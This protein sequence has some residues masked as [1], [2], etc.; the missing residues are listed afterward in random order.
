MRSLGHNPTQSELED[1]I[2][3]VDLD[4]N[5]SIDFSEFLAV[6]SRQKPVTDDE[7]NRE[8]FRTFDRDGDG[9]ISVDDLK[10][11]MLKLGMCFLFYKY[12]TVC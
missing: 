8:A 11:A 1:M 3:E 6:M 9:S 4:G 12:W 7:V 5:G 10:H 2:N